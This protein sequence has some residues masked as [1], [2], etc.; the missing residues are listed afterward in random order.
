MPINEIIYFGGN[1]LLLIILFIIPG[2]ISN[3]RLK[4]GCTSIA[5]WPFTKEFME[6][7]F[8][9]E[10]E[11]VG[12]ILG[13]LLLGT[14]IFVPVIIGYIVYRIG[15]YLIRKFAFSKEEKVQIAIGALRMKK[16]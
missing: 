4:Y 13:V 16:R 6:D 15:R 14:F 8:G 9:P 3:T 1:F 10:E 12:P 5:I 11:M 2:I 7:F